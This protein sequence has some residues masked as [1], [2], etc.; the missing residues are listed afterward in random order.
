MAFDYAKTAGQILEMVGGKANVEGLTHCITRL[1]F[2]LKDMGLPKDSEVEK[3]PGVLRVIK[4]GGQYQVVIG[5]EVTHVFA[6][7]QKLGDFSD[8][9]R[10][11]NGGPKENLF[12]RLCA[13]VAGCMTP[14]LPAMLGCGMIKVILTLL[15]TFN[16]VD[17][18]GSTYM[19]LNTVG[20]RV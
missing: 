18:T 11:E 14:L 6:E 15:T 13:F 17:T 16:L 10:A 7:L 5:N 12:S 9:G 1:R 3:I 19:I 20:E 4:Q 8:G 2:V